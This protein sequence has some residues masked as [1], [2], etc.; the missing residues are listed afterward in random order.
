MKIHLHP[1][2][3]AALALAA[4]AR[5]DVSLHPLFSEHAVLQQG[6]PIPVWG[7]ATPGETVTVELADARARATTDSQGH[8]SVSL[9]ALTAGGPHVLVVS[10]TYRIELRD[11]FVGEVWICSG[12]SNM[13]RQLGPR[14]GQPPIRDWEKEVAAA[15]LPKIRHFGVAQKTAFTP[16]ETVEG[17]WIVCSPQTA[18]D[19][20]AVG[21][22][23]ARALHAA[24]N[25]PIGLIHSSWGGTPAQA[26]TSADGLRK[27]DGFAAP[28]ARLE[29][30]A[31]AIANG[32]YDYPK[33]LAAWFPAHDAGSRPAEPWFTPALDTRDWSAMPLPALWESAG[34]DGLDGVVWFRREFDLPSEWQGVDLCLRLGVIDDIDTTWVNGEQVGSTSGWQTRREYTIP[35]TLLKPARNVV[36]VR[37]LDT[38]GGGGIW[39]PAEPLEVAPARAC[40]GPATLSLRGPWSHR[41]GAKF[42][43]APQPPADMSRSPGSPTVLYNAM[44]APLQPFA[45]RGVIWYQGEADVGRERQYRTLFPA[46]IADWR[47][48]WGQGEFPFLF[49]QIAPYRTMTPEIREAQLLSWQCTLNTAM[50]VTLDCGDANDIHPANK[51]P[52][53]ERLALAARA[54]AYGEA[55]EFSGPVYRA[56]EIRGA[57][58]VL[59]F[60]HTG[61]GLAAS[62]GGAL[63]GFTIAG[64]D[65]VFHPAKAFLAGDTLVVTSPAV[66]QPV[67]VRYAWANVPEGN[68]VNRAG[69]PASPFRTDIE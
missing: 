64:T 40:G 66:A 10:A 63:R 29:S 59:R 3:L 53:G 8:W 12:Q 47:R 69:L 6:R 30:V 49:V 19:F 60:D 67:A 28:L 38:G 51:K 58:A 55:I 42:P 36:A 56:L 22:F 54:L 2:L 26:W 5:A 11:V 27:L 62:D 25:V 65:R 52:V 33:E 37:V 61:D 41:V 20:T 44:I 16:Q 4:A 39:N 34:L 21:F 1:T 35:A 23:F 7:R 14:P 13:E 43:D 9:P 15:D 18:P 48:T 57:E 17:R 32:T 68:L 46:M 24:R 50:A 31:H 45:M